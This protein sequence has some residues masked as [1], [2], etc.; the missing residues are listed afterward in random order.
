[1]HPPHAPIAHAHACTYIRPKQLSRPPFCTAKRCSKYSTASSYLM[2][3]RF[4]SA[5]HFSTRRSC[6]RSCP[7]WLPQ[8]A[9]LTTGEPFWCR[10]AGRPVDLAK[11]G[12]Q[13]RLVSQS[14]AR[15]SAPPGRSGERRRS[16]ADPHPHIIRLT[17]RPPAVQVNVLTAGSIRCAGRRLRHVCYIPL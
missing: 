1:M 5:W 4:R 6:R 15:S 10:P 12:R 3:G 16:A 8:C 9:P 11:K 13:K 7:P 14:Q 2:A 17:D